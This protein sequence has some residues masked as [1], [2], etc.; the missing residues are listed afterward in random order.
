M[1][2]AIVLGA[3]GFLGTHMVFRLKNDG[4][5]VVG[6][7][8][9]HNE[10]EETVA[11]KFI[12]GDL[13]RHYFCKQV[14]RDTREYDLVI[15]LAADMGGA[16][17]I[18]T[19]EHDADI[20]HNSAQINLNVCEILK[21]TK[22]KIF[23]SSSAC[24]YPQ[25]NQLDPL[26]PKCAE[27]TSE[28]ASPD[29]AYGWEK[30]LSEKVYLA[31]AKNY[32]MDIRIARFHNIFGE[33]GVYDNERA[34]APAALINK[35]C[36]AEDGESIEVY[37]DGLQ[38]RSFLYVDECVEGVMRLLESDYK[39]PINIG[40]EEMVTIN[41]LAQLIIKISGKNLTI[42]NV[43]S[44][45]LGVRGRNSDNDLIREVLDWSPSEPLIRGIRKTFNWIN[46]RINGNNAAISPNGEPTV[47]N[48]SD[49]RPR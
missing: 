18:F 44:N 32:G 26:N 2:S 27:D 35:V 29:S 20:M 11:D 36:K 13:R 41:E 12:I 5:Y 42:K 28:P 39:L 40:S 38:T 25:Y 45:A 3:G 31:F 22:S 14:L 6:V 43:P 10:F 9:K 17:F 24:I 47:S 37:G 7:D 4:Y 23:Y 33:N 16:L 19:G 15:Q 46:Q 49:N 21:R 48:F 34:K 30:L 8:L 1:K